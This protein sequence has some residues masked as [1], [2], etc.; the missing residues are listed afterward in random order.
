MGTPGSGKGTQAE[1]L[2]QKYHLEHAST[3]ELFRQ[4]IA[5]KSNVGMQAK[6]IIEQGNLCPDEMTL[7]MLYKFCSSFNN[8]RGFILDGVPRTLKQAEMME[9]IGY[10]YMIPVVLAIYI[11][12]DKNE[13]VDRLDKRAILLKRTDDTPE[14]IRQ[15]IVNYENQ[16][17]PL[18]IHYRSQN[19]LI[20]IN[21]MQTIENVF[22][23]ICKMIDMY[24]SL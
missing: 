19:K 6:S 21:G 22:M 9:G 10:P 15:R 1:L 12:V 24:L 7:D 4:E 13:I 5:L 11:K 8:A 3:G 16:T 14:I 17:K 18:I 23:D 2:K 20:E